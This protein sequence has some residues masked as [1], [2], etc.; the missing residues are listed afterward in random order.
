MR[1]SGYREDCTNWA[2]IIWRGAV[3][4][5]IRGTRGQRF[6][7]DLITAL[8]ALPTPRLIADRLEVNGDVCALGSVGKL[9]GLSMDGLDPYDRDA[10][11]QTFGI[12]P[13]LAAEIMFENDEAGSWGTHTPEQRWRWMRQWTVDHVAGKP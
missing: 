12:A 11:A 7:R 3:T 8:D 5:A 10:M 2:L 6:L 1:R 4:S 13:A 9:R